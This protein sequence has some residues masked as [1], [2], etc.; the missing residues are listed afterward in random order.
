[1]KR[2]QLLAGLG[3]AGAAGLV[4]GARAQ[5]GARVGA[6]DMTTDVLVVG[7]GSAGASAAI[8]ASRA[9]AAVLVI[10]SLPR[11]GGSS[12]MSAG[13]V[14][15]G[16]GTALQ[17]A[18][19]VTDSVAAMAAFITGMSGPQPPLEKI[20]LYCEESAAH[21][22]WLVAQ[23]VRY[24][25][26]LY[27]GMTVPMDGESLY[28]SGAERAWP[29]RELAPPAPRGHV[30]LAANMTGGRA[31]ME[32]LLARVRELGVSLLSGVAAQRLVVAS[33]GRVLGMEV[34]MGGERKTVR[35]RRGV[36]LASGGFIHNREMVSLYAPHLYQCSV[37]WGNIGDQGVGI[38]I[39]IGAGAAALRMHQGF[40]IVP[41]YPPESVLSGIVVNAAG[42]RFVPED[43]YYGV[44]G[45]AIAYHQQGRA[46]L[47][48]DSGSH[49]PPQQDN[50]PQVAQ[51]NT[52]GDLA[53]QLQFPRG[54]L[55][56]TVAYYNRNAGNGEDPQFHKSAAFL[57][58]LQGP[59][60]RAWDLSVERAFV[61]AH[62]FGG[63]H[64]TVDGQVLDGFGDAIPGLYAAG[65]T[66]SGLPAA[67][68]IASGLS[69]GD[70]TFFGRRAGLAAANRSVT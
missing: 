60:Y 25:D 26:R 61:P 54:A 58:P 45:D 56:Q 38:N 46:W 37:P 59:P 24:G 65:R 69:V 2:R 17:Q 68:Y 48:T 6:W 15:A 23:G 53:E 11:F 57:R 28:F 70:C 5:P 43:T 27:T 16:G 22:D 41:L 1:M 55:Q 63:L 66:A 49:L 40:A 34:S 19:G 44:L 12:A 64:T 67:P 7:S 13:V 18:L 30:P 50:F 51:A 21:F 3:A 20:Q 10:E 32:A 4:G 35:A 39:G 8:E 9:G 29:A 52:V 33:D 36:V 62:T 31:L 42:Q 47:I 14:Y